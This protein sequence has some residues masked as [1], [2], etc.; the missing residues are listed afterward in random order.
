MERERV[1]GTRRWGWLFL[2]DHQRRGITVSGV[3]AGDRVR[4]RVRGRAR[5]ALARS[6]PAPIEKFVS[7]VTLPIE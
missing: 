5:V 3:G 1:V 6:D 4:S 2:F 7:A